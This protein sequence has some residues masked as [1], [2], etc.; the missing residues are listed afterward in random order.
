MAFD[1]K[2]AR[3]LLHSDE[4]QYMTKFGWINYT[5]KNKGMTMSL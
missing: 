1:R 4:D 2:E 5:E 3:K